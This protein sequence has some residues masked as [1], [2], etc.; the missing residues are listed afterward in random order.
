VNGATRRGFLG[1]AAAAAG[2]VAAPTRAVARSSQRF[3]DVAITTGDVIL[4]ARTIGRGEPI[5]MHPS[6]ARGGRDFDALALRLAARGYRAISFDPRGIGQSWAPASAL[7]GLDL[8][9]YARDMLAV[10]DHFELERAH[11][12]GHAYGNRVARTFATDHPRR[13][14]TVILCACGGGIPAPEVVRG[15]SEVTDPETSAA[16]IRRV[17]ER[18][19]FAPGNDPSPWYLG[20]YA[21]AGRAEQLS[22]VRTDFAASEGGGDKPTLIVQG[23]QDIVA[24]PAI[25]HDLRRRYGRRITVRDLDHAGHAMIIER[26]DAVAR[27]MLDFLAR[28]PLGRG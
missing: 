22:V 12:F 13:S 25:G 10:V 26:T 7:E 28:H 24:P 5:V 20:W 1:L 17:T 6:L 19:F 8:H 21:A 15:L 23:K 16:E 27:V 9:A 14:A 11:V 3:A 4:A 18:V 2:A